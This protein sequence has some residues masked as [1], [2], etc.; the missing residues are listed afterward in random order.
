[1]ARQASRI[2]LLNERRKKISLFIVLVPIFMKKIA[3]RVRVRF[4]HKGGQVFWG[5]VFIGK[6][7][8][9]G[10]FYGNQNYQQ[11]KHRQLENRGVSGFN[12]FYNR[13]DTDGA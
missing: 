13:K 9:I 12:I 6:S 11:T 4:W 8:L 5:R 3:T 10:N 2:I 7:H 1:M